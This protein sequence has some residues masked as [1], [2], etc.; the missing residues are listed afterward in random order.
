M[1]GD[2]P[3]DRGL[4]RSGFADQ[5]KGLTWKNVEIYA[6]DGHDRFPTPARLEMRR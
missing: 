4:A 5:T 6:I 1:A 2:H 3:S